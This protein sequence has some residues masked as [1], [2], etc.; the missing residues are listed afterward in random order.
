MSEITLPKKYYL[1][2]GC[3]FRNESDSILEWIQH[4]IYHGVEHFYMIDDTSSDDSILKIHPYIE[5]GWITLFHGNNWPR[6]LG[7]QHEMYNHFILPY[8][9]ETQWLLMVDLDEY[10]WSQVNIDLKMVIK[11]ISQTISQIQF[12]HT[13]FGSNGHISQPKN[14]IVQNFTKRT[15][16]QPTNTGGIIKYIVN[17][18]YKYK[19]LNIH[20]A[21]PIENKYMEADYFRR[22]ENPW[23]ILNHYCCQ[24]LD[25]WRDI[26]CTRGDGDYYLVRTMETFKHFDINDVEDRELAN[27]NRDIPPN[28]GL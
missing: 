7:R 19:S 4:Y 8:L 23:F 11:Q 17:S 27:Q 5:A 6:H 15:K 26:K 25:F 16:E 3:V 22:F 10:L 20:Y 1:S 13:M 14:G 28:I 2:V 18:D 21:D 12:Y 9:P 24:S